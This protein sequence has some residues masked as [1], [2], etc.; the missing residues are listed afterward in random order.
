M[1]QL[2]QKSRSEKIET[3]RGREREK[4]TFVRDHEECVVKD[5][6]AAAWIARKQ[7]PLEVSMKGEAVEEGTRS[8]FADFKIFANP[9]IPPF[10]TF[11]RLIAIVSFVCKLLCAFAHRE[12]RSIRA[13]S[14]EFRTAEKSETEGWRRVRDG[15]SPE[16][17]RVECFVGLNKSYAP[18]I[19]RT[20][21]PSLVRQ[22]NLDKF[23]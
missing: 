11:D 6:V 1:F 10:P 3:E 23:A 12:C 19:T 18:L 16:S 7:C 20:S 17:S 4:I 15:G 22:T 2:S 21:V 9:S 5:D 13:Q 8:L 14:A